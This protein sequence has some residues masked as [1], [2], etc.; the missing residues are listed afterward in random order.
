M[1][2]KEMNPTE[3]IVLIKGM[4]D[5]AKNRLADDGFL[6]IFWGWLVFGAATI[7]HI[8]LKLGST[9]GELAWPVLMLTGGIISIMYSIKQR[10]KSRVRSYLDSY[11]GF[12][13]GSFMIGL[14]L[15]LIFMPVHGL[16]PSYF[17]IMLL[18]GMATFVSG[19]LLRFRQLIVG[20]LFSFAFAV[21]SV[22]VSSTD[23]LLCIAGAVLC[24]Y[25]IP[26]H[27]LR[28]RYRSQSDV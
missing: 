13:W 25:I 20:S 28:A 26:G 7:Q 8:S 21:I 12:S 15:A 5:T 1:Q 9:S 22:Y 17:F 6:L 27:M 4:I 23:L 16:K 14:S 24:S 10:N 11:L 19:G 18:Y 3:S 2:E